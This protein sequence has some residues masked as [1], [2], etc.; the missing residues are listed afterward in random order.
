MKEKYEESME[1]LKLYIKTVNFVPSEKQWNKYAL[2][3]CLFSSKSLEYYSGIKFNVLCR[4]IIKKKK[5]Y[6]S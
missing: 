6:L 3:E 4:K 5:S 1:A 2:Q